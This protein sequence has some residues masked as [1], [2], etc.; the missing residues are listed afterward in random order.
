MLRVYV[1]NCSEVPWS[2][3]QTLDEVFSFE[4]IMLGLEVIMLLEILYVDLKAEVHPSRTNCG[5]RWNIVLIYV[6]MEIN[7]SLSVHFGEIW[8]YLLL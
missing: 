4:I 8:A 1:Y 2:D 7:E 5:T 6:S 3:I